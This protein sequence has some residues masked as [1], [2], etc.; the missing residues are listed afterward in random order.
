MNTKTVN[1]KSVSKVCAQAFVIVAGI[2]VVTACTDLSLPEHQFAKTK[3]SIIYTY[4]NDQGFVIAS[5]NATV[6]CNQRPSISQSI[7]FS[8]DP[9]G[10]KA[11]IFECRRTQ[12]PEVTMALGRVGLNNDHRSGLNL[13]NM[14]RD[15][16]I[17]CNAHDEHPSSSSNTLNRDGINTVTVECAPVI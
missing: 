10:A 5:Q 13:P 16:R 12:T 15:A 7:T 17:Q 4:R 1:M 14:P 8:G 3:P 2:M 9:R 11:V 6:F